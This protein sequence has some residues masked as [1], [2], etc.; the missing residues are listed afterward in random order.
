MKE[1]NV[2][3]SQNQEVS[4]LLMTNVQSQSVAVKCDSQQMFRSLGGI[5]H[6]SDQLAQTAP[7]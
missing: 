3:V 1:Y 6:C 4:K 2:S 5:N 7:R